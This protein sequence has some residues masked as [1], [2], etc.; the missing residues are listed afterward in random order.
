MNTGFMLDNEI[1]GMPDSDQW[2]NWLFRGKKWRAK[3]QQ[4]ADDKVAGMVTW[5]SGDDCDGLQDSMQ[6]TDRIIDDWMLKTGNNKFTKEKERMLNALQKTRND[7]K[8]TWEDGDCAGQRLEEEKAEFDSKVG[9]MMMG[10]QDRSAD[11]SN[12]GNKVM[13]VAIGVGALVMIGVLVLA[14]K[15]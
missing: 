13:Q 7:I 12:S 2:S 9:D 10:I 5:D 6:D 11:R 8:Y 14:F 15:K 1:Y 4:K 3:Q